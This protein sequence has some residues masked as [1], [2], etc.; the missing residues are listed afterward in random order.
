MQSLTAKIE[1]IVVCVQATLLMFHVLVGRNLFR[2]SCRRVSVKLSALTV[3]HSLRK[4]P[5][6]PLF[7]DIS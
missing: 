5:D 6:T 7:T 1:V 3:C 2:R 4:I